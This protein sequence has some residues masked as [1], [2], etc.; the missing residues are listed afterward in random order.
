VP[1]LLTFAAVALVV[2]LVVRAL[3]IRGYYDDDDR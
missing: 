3:R 2:A 1:F